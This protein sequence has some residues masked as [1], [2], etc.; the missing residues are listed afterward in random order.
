[1]LVCWWDFQL[2]THWGRVK[3]IC[4]GNLTI[5]GSENGLSPGERKAIIW[6]SAIILL[7][8][9]LGT[10][11]SE[12][13][14]EIQTFSFKKMHENGLLPVWHQAITWTDVEQLIC[15]KEIWNQGIRGLTWWYGLYWSVVGRTIVSIVSAVQCNT[16]NYDNTDHTSSHPSFFHN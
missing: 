6:T 12:I 3:H 13:L 1:M 14:I 2:L 5:I 16:T 15:Y 7:I 4:I 10:N 9:S 8:E 11:F